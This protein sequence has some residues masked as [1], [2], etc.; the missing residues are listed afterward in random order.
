VRAARPALATPAFVQRRALSSTPVRRADEE[1]EA[2]DSN[3][4]R[5]VI[6]RYYSPG[7]VL[8]DMLREDGL[9]EGQKMIINKKLEEWNQLPVD[10]QKEFEDLKRGIVQS[11][12]QIKFIQKPKRDSFWNADEKDSDLIT[13]E[14]GE[15]DFEEDDMLS[16]GH[17]K[18]EEHREA[19]EY[20][21]IA[22][23]EMPLLSSKEALRLT[24]TEQEL[25]ISHRVR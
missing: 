6:K 25:N 23:W 21:R 13:D 24:E 16:I 5:E 7:E 19:R 8:K 18:L 2:D 14:I 17:A 12:A 3:E 20:A 4:T 22:V 1:D 11:T 10:K 15:D 9:S